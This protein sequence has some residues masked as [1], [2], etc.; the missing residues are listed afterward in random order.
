MRLP[1]HIASGLNQLGA[2]LVKDI[3]QH[4]GFVFCHPLPHKV[5]SL[6]LHQGNGILD[7]GIEKRQNVQFRVV[8]HV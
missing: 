8:T 4:G 6:G 1:Y 2:T 3:E 7:G 5:L